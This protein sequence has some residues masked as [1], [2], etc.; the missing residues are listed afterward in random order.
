MKTTTFSFFT[1]SSIRDRVVSLMRDEHDVLSRAVNS[2]RVSTRNMVLDRG[3][4]KYGMGM[5]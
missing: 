4:Y 3:E 2:E 1:R 5:K